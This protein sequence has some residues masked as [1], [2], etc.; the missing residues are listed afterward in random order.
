MY[1]LMVIISLT[2]VAALQPLDQLNAQSPPGR[3]TASSFSSDITAAPKQLQ[4]HQD[5]TE[6]VS[7]GSETDTETL[8]SVCGFVTSDIRK[9]L[10][11]RDV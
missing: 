6:S 3:T 2:I 10:D 11:P 7:P 8:G 1:Y 5:V 9:R 4:W